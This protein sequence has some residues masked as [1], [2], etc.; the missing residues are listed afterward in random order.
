MNSSDWW[1]WQMYRQVAVFVN[2]PSDS[3]EAKLTML[4]EQ[5]QEFYKSQA[6]NGEIPRSRDEHEWAMDFR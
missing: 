4:M 6:F 1:L 5:Y 3:T 2:Q